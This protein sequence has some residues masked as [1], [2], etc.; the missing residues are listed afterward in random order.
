M[1]EIRGIKVQS[2]FLYFFLFFIFC[3]FFFNKSNKRMIQDVGLNIL[4]NGSAIYCY[5]QKQAKEHI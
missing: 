4:K 2:T 5:K 3:I 1:N